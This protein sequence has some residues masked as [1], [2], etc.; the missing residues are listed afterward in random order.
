MGQ[1]PWFGADI[2]DALAHLGAPAYILDRVG[3]IRWM[4][5]RAIELLGDHRG[6]HFTATVA[7][8]AEQISRL[9]FAKKMLGTARTSDYETVLVLRSGAHVPV[10]LHAV[11]L[12]DGDEVV[13]VFGIIDVDEHVVERKPPAE[14]TPR[15]HE[16]L[17]ALARGSSTQQIAESLGISRET[18]R[19]HV[20]GLLGALGVNSR[21]EA[22]VEARRRG[23][24]D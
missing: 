2:G 1:P 8:E 11:T 13:G 4:N 23:L 18:V 12:A 7:S 24:I 22:L 9:E 20:R 5:P 6:E 16:V 3:V 14:L 21:I 15:Q 17:R 10:E 19:N